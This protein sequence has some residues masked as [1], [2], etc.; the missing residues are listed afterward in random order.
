VRNETLVATGS[1][2]RSDPHLYGIHPIAIVMI[3]KRDWC[4]PWYDLMFPEGEDVSPSAGC[5]AM[6]CSDK[7]VDN[8]SGSQISGN[9]KAP[10]AGRGV[11]R[12]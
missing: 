6:R 7:I 8:S 2:G 12:G 5:R 9:G 3:G 1:G 11:G 4:A 10:R